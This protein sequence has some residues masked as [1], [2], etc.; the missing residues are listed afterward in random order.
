MLFPNQPNPICWLERD[1]LGLE[2][3]GVGIETAVG[4]PSTQLCSSITDRRP[5]P[6]EK[7]YYN[8]AKDFCSLNAAMRQ[9]RQESLVD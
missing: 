5:P 4:S 6:K 2:E 1:P 3:V 9:W 7:K 8:I